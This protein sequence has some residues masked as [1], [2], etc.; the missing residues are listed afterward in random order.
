MFT[1]TDYMNDKCTHQEYF[2]QFITPS[3]ECWVRRNYTKEFLRECLEADP[4]LNNLGNNWLR[5][6][7]IFIESIKAEIAAINKKINE[8][9]VWS[10]SDGVCAIKAYMRIYAN[11]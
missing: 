4:N 7:D 1:R 9:S 2:E 10:Y 5:K 3:I 8:Q 6:F 11:S